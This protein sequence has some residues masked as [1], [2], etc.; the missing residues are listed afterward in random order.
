VK[1]IWKDIPGYEGCYQASNL[2]NIKSLNYNKTKFSKNLVL[3][4]QHD[5][6]VRVTLNNK[7][8][9]VHRLIGITFIPNIFNYHEINHINGI[10]N[11]NKVV[12]LEWCTR[13][14]NTIH[15]IKTGL[16]RPI[17][18][19]DSIRKKLS[20]GKIGSKN[21]ASKLKKEDIIFILKNKKNYT[22]KEIAKMFN[23]S[24]YYVY[25]LWR[26]KRKTWKHI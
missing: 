17:K 19:T 20:I 21:P 3:N 13:S 22:A 10:K 7:S 4:K 1:E 12:N 18:Y 24:S 9:P 16:Q 15:A 26:K 5:G 8:Y 14:M 25:D 6:Y 23:I 2:G 11:D